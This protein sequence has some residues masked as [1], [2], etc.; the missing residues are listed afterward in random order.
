M[1][2]ERLIAETGLKRSSLEAY[3][4]SASKRYYVFPIKKRD[5]RS[6]MIAH[7]ARPIKALQRWANLRFLSQFPIHDCA[8]A[9]RKGMGIKENA[10][11]HAGSRYTT[12]LDIEDFFPSF[13]ISGVIGFL[14]EK[15]SD[16]THY[17]STD[18]DFF[19]KIFT[20]NDEI[21]IGAPS[22]P[23]LT[24][25]M[26][27]EFD[28][29]LFEFSKE[30]NLIYTRYADDIFLSSNHP[31][32]MN[33]VD[34]FVAKLL[35]DFKFADFKSNKNKTKHLN[36]KNHRSLTGLVLKPDCGISIGR[37]RKREIKSQVFY[38][39]R[40]KNAEIDIDRLC[41]LVAFA[42]DVEPD[43][44][45]RLRDKYT[46]EVIQRLLKRSNQAT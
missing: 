25:L 35:E 20:I 13:K 29:A 26:M 7:P 17:D 5:G 15:I 4:A 45:Q 18:V 6:R 12:R 19:A 23:I 10:R 22:S 27:Y 38:F 44:V 11:R 30:N 32:K 28:T 16:Y 24:N 21:T 40:G 34:L 9:Y 41:G 14:N 2:L 36:R 39:S 37:N 8:T 33:D 1:L 3:A 46:P 42:L 31:N 43:F